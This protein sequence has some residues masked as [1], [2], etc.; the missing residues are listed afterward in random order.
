MKNEIT[1]SQ[2][3]RFPG[4]VKRD[5]AIEVWMREHA[6]EL[7]AIAQRWF[8]VMRD[9]GEDVRELLHDGH[10]TACVGDAAFAYVNAFKAHVNVGFF[11]GAEIADPEGLS[12][13]T[14]KFMRHVKLRPERD[15]DAATLMKLIETAYTDMKSR[16]KAE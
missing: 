10:P 13:G 5:P 8:D 1:M 16:F 14:G 11:R 2:L 7:G 4:S 12:E 3:L 9:C 15:V 6:G